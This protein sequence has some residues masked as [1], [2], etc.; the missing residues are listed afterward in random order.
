MNGNMTARTLS[1]ANDR[2]ISGAGNSKARPRPRVRGGKRSAL[3]AGVAALA[4]LASTALGPGEAHGETLPEAIGMT[5]NQPHSRIARNS[6]PSFMAFE[7]SLGLDMAGSALE[8]MAPEERAALEAV[9]VFLDVLRNREALGMAE[10]HL[11]AQRQALRQGQAMASQ[12]GN[13]ALILDE[14]AAR[15]AQAQ[16]MLLRVRGHL[17]DSESR[18]FATVGHMPGALEIPRTPV[19]YVPGSLPEAVEQTLL[20]PA[21]GHASPAVSYGHTSLASLPPAEKEALKR[22]VERDVRIAWGR[23]L[24]SRELV[25]VLKDNIRTRNNALARM[26]QQF[27]ATA[28]GLPELMDGEAALFA[29]RLRLL[30]TQHAFAY[31]NYQLLAVAGRLAGMTGQGGNPAARTLPRAP[32]MPNSAWH[33]ESIS[34][35]MALP[36]RTASRRSA[37]GYNGAHAARGA[38]ADRMPAASPAQS[39][40][41]QGQGSYSVQLG[42][43]GNQARAE[44]AANVWK[45][46]GYQVEIIQRDSGSGLYVLVLPGFDSFARASME[47]DNIQQREDVV[48]LVIKND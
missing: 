33:N 42:T 32:E 29:E 41:G 22:A 39:F 30:N 48:A 44:V 13:A 10:R 15:L 17:R 8:I 19:E 11:V 23:I 3:M 28:M 36:D 31:A 37:Y 18:Y 38:N 12:S 34:D 20:S 35:H 43:F 4:I 5:L 14:A 27:D 45:E 46:R 40:Q 1:R 16:E 26:R 24:T 25:P 2:G 6:S 9:A 7:Q 47:A 21:L